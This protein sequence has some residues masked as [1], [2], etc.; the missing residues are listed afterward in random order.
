MGLSEITLA[1]LA[2][3]P[4]PV[5]ARLRARSPVAHVPELG[6]W[7]VTGREA[8]VTVL[9]DPGTF[10]V[11][12]PRFSTAQVVGTSMLSTDGAEHARHR[13]PFATSFRPRR[14]QDHHSAAVELEV[15]RR[16]DRITASPT[17]TAELR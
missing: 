4:H 15:D 3:D 12:D 6:G 8:A 9:H 10:T 16:L 14:V 11:D 1:E 13:E 2:E 5:L 17:G 7:L